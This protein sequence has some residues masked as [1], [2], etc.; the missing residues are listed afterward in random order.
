MPVRRILMG[1]DPQK[2]ANPSAMRDPQALEFFI[3]YAARSCQP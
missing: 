2:V 1:H 3:E